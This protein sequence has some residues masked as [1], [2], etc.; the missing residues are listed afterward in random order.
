LLNYYFVLHSTVTKLILYRLS[1]INQL[2]NEKI[3]RTLNSNQLSET[4]SNT[5]SNTWNSKRRYR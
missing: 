5:K 4:L 3:M 1:S 2:K